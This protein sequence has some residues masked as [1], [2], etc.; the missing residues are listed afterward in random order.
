MTRLASK[1]LMVKP[2]GFRAN[3]ETVMDN[4]FIDDSSSKSGSVEA[5]AMQEF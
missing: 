4:A 3:E 1:V 5:R 2:V